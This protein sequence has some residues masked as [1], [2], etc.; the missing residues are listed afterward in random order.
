MGIYILSCTNFHRCIACRMIIEMDKFEVNDA[1]DNDDL[2]IYN[3]NTLNNEK[4]MMGMILNFVICH[5][6]I[7][8]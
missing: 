6:I 5:N 7:Q 2:N 1:H 4:N 8:I 3:M